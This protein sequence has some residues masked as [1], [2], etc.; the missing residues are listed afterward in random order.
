MLNA[1]ASLSEMDEVKA[2]IGKVISSVE[3]NDGDKYANF[4]P[5]VDNVAA[6]TIGGLVAGKILAKVGFFALIVKFWKLIA[7][8]VAGA[9][10]AIFKFFK[11]KKDDDDTTLS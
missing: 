3:F 1:V 7:L 6:W 10:A 11:K 8:G 2:S 4:N 9:G 5:D